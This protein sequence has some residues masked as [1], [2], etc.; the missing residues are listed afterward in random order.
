MKMKRFL[1]LMLCLMMILGQ[2]L[3]ADPFITLPETFN[4]QFITGG[5]GVR[6]YVNLKASGVAPWLDVLLPFTATQI[7][8]RAIGREQGDY[9]DLLNDDDDWQLKLYMK[10]AAN[11]EKGVTY[12]YGDPDAMYISSELLPETLL[13]L[14]VKDVHLLYDIAKR[15]IGSLLFG[16]DPFA[17]T[18]NG[19][20][21][22][23][24]A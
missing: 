16:F 1:C 7:Q 12:L 17:M 20:G 2:A 21:G 10:D 3:A 15:D 11:T 4:A 13:T 6:G 14:P 23:A 24:T 5:F 19:A 8:L 9:S 22:I 18:G